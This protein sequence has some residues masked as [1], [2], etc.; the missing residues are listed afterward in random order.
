M[1]YFVFVEQ[2]PCHCTPHDVISGCTTTLRAFAWAR[3][4]FSKYTHIHT[5]A[6]LQ[7]AWSINLKIST[8]RL[9]FLLNEKDCVLC[10]IGV[11]ACNGYSIYK[12]TSTHIFH[13]LNFAY[14]CTRYGWH[15]HTHSARVSPNDVKRRENGQNLCENS[16]TTMYTPFDFR[17]WIWF[18]NVEVE[19]STHA[20]MHVWNRSLPK[21]NPMKKKEMAE[22][23]SFAAFFLNTQT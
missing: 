4:R 11:Y 16:I 1:K 18:E 2:R 17:K 7:W 6:H 14:L 13:P 19:R 12:H 21:P 5:C 23:S 22:K 3:A 10:L 15:T 8:M 9:H 20:C